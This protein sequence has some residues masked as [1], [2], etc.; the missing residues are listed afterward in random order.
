[1]KTGKKKVRKDEDVER[2]KLVKIQRI[3]NVR[4]EDKYNEK[5]RTIVFKL[6]K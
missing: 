1:M 6:I 5:I 3:R 4:R 2:R